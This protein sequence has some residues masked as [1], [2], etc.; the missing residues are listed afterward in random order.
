MTNLI[1]NARM[2]SVSPAAEAAWRELLVHVA[3]EAGVPMAYTPYPAPQ[4]LEDL[5]ARGD[6]GAVQMCGYPIALR[7]TPNIPIAAPIPAADWAKG[8]PLYRSDIIVRADSPYRK[9]E[10]T[11]AGTLGWTVEHSHSGFNALRHHLLKYHDARHPTL[12]NNVKGN[13]ITARRIVDSV[14]DGTID[15]GPL[16]GYWHMLLKLHLPELTR[17][18]RVLESTDLAPIPA[19]VASPTTDAATVTALKDAFAAAHTRAWFA[20]LGETLALTGF[21]PVSLDDYAETLAWDSE[22]L[23][24]GYP[25]PA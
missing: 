15:V 5:W 9:L 12:Y 24:A 10:D 23:A 6:L 19:F 7:L 21:Q 1:A 4:P 2:Y 20:P 11:F 13:L 18:I 25:L 3:D 17:G 8:K 22:A 14:R 16:D